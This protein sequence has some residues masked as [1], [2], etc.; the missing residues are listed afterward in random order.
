[1]DADDLLVSGEF[2]NSLMDLIR[3]ANDEYLRL[4]RSD[5][6]RQPFSK[7]ALAE[8]E[9]YVRASLY[10]V[11]LE[12][13]DVEGE[14]SMGGDFAEHLRSFVLPLGGMVRESLPDRAARKVVAAALASCVAAS[15]E[16]ARDLKLR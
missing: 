16:D 14:K 10:A 1:M 7:I 11:L 12:A 8:R 6:E 2:R 5:H 9:H 3:C 13:F 15:A 4:V